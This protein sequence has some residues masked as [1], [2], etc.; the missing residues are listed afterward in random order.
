MFLGISN[1]IGFSLTVLAFK[2]MGAEIVL[3]ISI[4]APMVLVLL[5]GRLVYGEH[6]NRQAWIGCM[7]AVLAVGVLSYGSSR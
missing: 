5:M 6:L 3:P 1:T 4:T 2:D 7:L